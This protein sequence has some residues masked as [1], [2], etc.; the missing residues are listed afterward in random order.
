MG[1][2][3]ACKR[4]GAN[5]ETIKHILI[6]CPSFNED[7]KKI[8]DIDK[9]VSDLEDTANTIARW[10]SFSSTKRNQEQITRNTKNL[11]VK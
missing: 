9:N 5:R 6:E 7:R 4:R 11:L 3:P 1:G 10:L 8:R 2:N